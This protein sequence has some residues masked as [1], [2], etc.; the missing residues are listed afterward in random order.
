MILI[1]MLRFHHVGVSIRG[2][3]PIAGWFYIEKS[4]NQMD[5]F[6]GTPM[7]YRKPPYENHVF[8]RILMNVW[9]YFL[10]ETL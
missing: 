9:N 4:E 10:G 8:F 6:E 5:D 7:T 1:N 2:G 3:T